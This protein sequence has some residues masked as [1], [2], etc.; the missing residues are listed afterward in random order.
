MKCGG[1]PLRNGLT[2]RRGCSICCNNSAPS[3]DNLLSR[4]RSEVIVSCCRQR[5]ADFH[6]PARKS[7]VAAIDEYEMPPPW[8]NTARVG[9]CSTIARVAVD[10]RGD[11]HFTFQRALRVA[12]RRAHLDRAGG[13]IEETEIVAI[14]ASNAVETRARGF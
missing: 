11:I 4:L 2:T 8:K 9:T 3:L 13:R 10:C 5:G 1:V 6:L 14:L 7:A 12:Q